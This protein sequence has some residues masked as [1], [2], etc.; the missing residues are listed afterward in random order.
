[1]PWHLVSVVGVRGTAYE[2]ARAGARRAARYANPLSRLAWRR[3]A[4]ILVLNPETQA[5]LP[6]RYQHKTAILPNAVLDQPIMASVH[7]NENGTA[8]FAGR[9]LPWKGVALAIEAI[10]KAPGWKLKICGQGADAAR[11]RRLAARNG[12]ASRVSFEGWLARDEL[13]RVM[14]EESDVFLFPSLHDDSPWAVVEALASGLSV[15]CLDRGGPRLLSGPA[16]VV[17]GSAGD[18]RS[19]ADE[20][21]STLRTRAFRPAQTSHSQAREY[22]LAA[23]IDQLRA[24]LE[25]IESTGLL[26]PAESHA[27]D[28]E[29]YCHAGVG[30]QVPNEIR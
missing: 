5:W 25:S 2:V 9:L 26:D 16:G 22:A 20:L 12:V 8:L 4:L 15:I 28:C 17:I 13:V 21:A 23:R 11:L 24:E 1:M 6:R 30:R 18:P 3:A 7:R 14:R 29:Q 19:I 27:P 10:A